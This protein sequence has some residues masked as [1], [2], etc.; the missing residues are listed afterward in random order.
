MP[1]LASP[2]TWRTHPHA[3]TVYAYI[4][5]PAVIFS[6]SVNQSSFDYPLSQV[7]YDTVTTGAYTDVKQYMTVRISDAS[8]NFKAF[9]YARELP[10]STLL[11]IG[12]S[13]IGD[14]DFANND[15]IEVLEDFRIWAKIPSINAVGEQF[16][17]WVIVFNEATSQPPVANASPWYANKVDGSN[18]ITVDFPG[19]N[20]FPVAP[21]ASISGYLWD[22]GDGTIT[23]G[24]SS[25]SSI[26]A[27]FPPGERWVELQV[28]DSDGTTHKAH[29]LVVAATD[30][31]ALQVEVASLQGD[32]DSGWQLG[33]RLLEGDV[34]AYDP[35]SAIIVWV[36]ERYGSTSGSLNGFADREHVIFSGWLVEENISIEPLQSDW[37]VSAMNAVGIL[38]KTP[39][40]NQTTEYAATASSWFEISEHNLWRHAHY[41]MQWHSTLLSVCDVERPSW[42]ASWSAVALDA[43]GGSLYEQFA[44]VANAV[45]ARFT[46]DRNGRCYWRKNPQFMTTAE[47]SS[48]TTTVTLADTDWT[49]SVNIRRNHRL[50]V[51]ILW[52]DGIVSDTV[53]ITARKSAAPGTTPGQGERQDTLT[54][55]LISDQADL[56]TRTGRA[57]GLANLQD[58]TVP[59]TVLLGGLVADPAWLEQIVWTLSTDK[60]TREYGYT[61]QQFGLRSVRVSY[62]HENGTT[63][64]DWELE[65][66]VDVG[67]ADGITVQLPGQ[68]PP[69][70][71]DAYI[72]SG[73]TITQ[74]LPYPPAP[75]PLEP[76]FTS[77][78]VILS[79]YAMI[80]NEILYTTAEATQANPD[81]L[82]EFDDT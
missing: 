2:S 46:C 6:C 40:F 13:S 26:T 29:T 68:D 43:D 62:D 37:D 77:G 58:P 70:G 71:T 65:K 39:A 22:V 16:K 11:Y 38:Q 73:G 67:A 42:Y 72:P 60:S 80:W 69:A 51:G 59:I 57:Y 47:R 34:S 33:L 27:T 5:Q 23:V 48:L 64:E 53:A 15:I 17:D 50:P 3:V 21:G 66:L 45:N 1:A 61:A 36:E 32:A 19:T 55:Q 35:G 56:N 74:Q 9:T 78:E 12:V 24:T 8:G 81:Y 30:A 41:L 25:S 54:R 20:S 79:V 4:S 44:F 75:E 14:I 82:S 49:D 76:D 52:G 18:I 10:S 31:T 28:T 63:E 7:E